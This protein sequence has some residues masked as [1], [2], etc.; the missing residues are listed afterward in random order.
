MVPLVRA[1]LLLL[2]AWAPSSSLAYIPPRL[3]TTTVR[4]LPAASFWRWHH[5]YAAPRPVA[6]QH[7]NAALPP[8]TALAAASP[9]QD[10]PESSSK[11]R[12]RDIPG[13]AVRI[14]A[15]YAGRLWNETNPDA[16]RAIATTKAA[17]AIRQVQHIIRGDEYITQFAAID[18]QPRQQLL[19]ACSDLLAAMDNAT[20]AEGVAPPAPNALSAAMENA[21]ATTTWSEANAVALEHGEGTTTTGPAKK[22]GRRSILFGATMG[23]AVAGWVFSG[24]YIFTGIFTLMTLLG[25][26][27]YYRMVIN[28]GVYPARRISVVGACSMFLTALFTPNYHQLC[29]PLFG[30][31]AMIWFLTMKRTPTTIPQIATTFTGMFYLGYVPSFWVRIRLLG[32]GREPT[33]L[34]P[35][36]GPFLR[37]IQ[38]KAERRLPSFLP[39]A[40]HLPITTGAIF[41]FWSWLCLAFADVGAYF[42]GKNFGKTKLSK[43]SPAAGAT[44]PNKTVEGVVGGCVVSAMLGMLGKCLYGRGNVCA[45]VCVCVS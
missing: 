31:W 8:I 38:N 23:L 7:N 15:D 10:A 2:I 24:S 27:E 5:G 16:R 14:Y 33:R 41:I 9:K 37:A 36:A 26:L 32:A 35:L 4:Q 6:H 12:K 34:A 30:L 20:L 40:V 44:S 13:E 1:A 28:T 43:I 21:T 18:D 39:K 11:L 29:L 25:Q 19:D 45:C 22:K 42:V 17:E 3:L